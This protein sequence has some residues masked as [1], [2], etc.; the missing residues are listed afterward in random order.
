MK[1]LKILLIA[2]GAFVMICFIGLVYIG[3]VAPETFVY[4]KNDIPKK[5]V[6]EMRDLS[7][8]QSK[9]R[10]QYMY[11]DGLLDIKDGLYA[12]TDQHLI[13][14]NEEWNEPKTIIEFNDIIDLYIDYDDSFLD[15]SYISVETKFGIQ[16]N[17]PVSSEKGRDRDFFNY[18]NKKVEGSN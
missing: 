8:L 4:N 12:L 15:D 6:D 16:V 17:F 13:L 18:L 9:E 11:S 7:L 3:M 2:F 1:I 5:Y 10:V 14:Y